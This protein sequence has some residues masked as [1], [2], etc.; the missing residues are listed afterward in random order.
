M[1]EKFLEKTVNCSKTQVAR[2]EFS[3][4]LTDHKFAYK[5]YKTQVARLI[6]SLIIK[7]LTKKNSMNIEMKMKTTEIKM[8]VESIVIKPKI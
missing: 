7:W 3:P 4:S 5:G 6:I 1:L 8:K 2:L